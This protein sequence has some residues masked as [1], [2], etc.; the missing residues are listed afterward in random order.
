MRVLE[1]KMNGKRQTK[2]KEYPKSCFAKTDQ[3]K[4]L[5]TGNKTGFKG[6]NMV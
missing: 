5:Y 1:L 2:K 6:S 4:R 3:S